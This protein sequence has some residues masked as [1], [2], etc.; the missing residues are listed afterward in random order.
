MNSII[1][2]FRG[3]AEHLAGL[4]VNLANCFEEYEV[5]VMEQSN[6]SPF[7]RG[8]LLNLGFQRSAGDVIVLLDVDMRFLVPIN[9][10]M[11]LRKWQRPLLPFSRI[12]QVSEDK[13]GNLK[14]LESHERL[15]AYGGCN[16]FLR[17]D[18]AA[19]GGFSNMLRGW[20]GEDNILNERARFHRLDLP[21]AHVKH[22]TI[23]AFEKK[24]DEDY[25]HN[26]RM[27]STHAE[28]ITEL[29]GWRQTVGVREEVKKVSEN[30]KHFAFEEIWVTKDFAYKD[31]I[32]HWEER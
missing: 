30:V 10:E 25:L 2:P 24:A 14:E 11:L 3:R 6:C 31:Y 4:L 15:E 26:C 22:G 17:E 21:L 18:F 9:V 23:K 29:D 13:E 19:C 5:L 7:K 20:G 27:L 8:Q 28:R 12:T 32:L 1:V 16:L